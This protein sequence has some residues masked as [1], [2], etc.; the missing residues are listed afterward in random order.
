MVVFAAGHD[1]SGNGSI[2]SRQG[3]GSAAR[4]QTRQ[5]ELHD[6]VTPAQEVSE[7]EAGPPTTFSVRAL[8]DVAEI[9]AT[10][11]GAL[12]RAGLI[13]YRRGRVTSLD[14]HG[15]E[16][17]AC[18]C[19]AVTKPALDRLLGAAAPARVLRGAQDIVHS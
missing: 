13:N 14:R 10:A 19:Y 1:R 11:A 3:A 6:A 18:E 15:L 2:A 5:R 4:A 17:A 8:L 12:Q 7:R 9:R 16:D